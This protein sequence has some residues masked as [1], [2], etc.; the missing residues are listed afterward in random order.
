MTREFIVPRWIIHLYPPYLVG[1]IQDKGLAWCIK[2]IP[3]YIIGLI[4]DT[5]L[6]PLAIMLRVVLFAIKP[7]V[8]IRF[9]QLWCDRL[10]PFAMFPELYLC[11][12]DA[13]VKP[14]KYLDIWYHYDR[15]AYLLQ[16]PVN[17]S[18]AIC[19]QQLDAMWK[20]LI[21]VHDVARYMDRLNRILKPGSSD[22]VVD[23]ATEMADRENLLDR[24]PVHLRF[25]EEEE[26]RGLEGLQELGIGP[27]D[28]FV[29]FHGRDS[30][31]L[32]KARPRNIE[33]H[34]DWSRHD[35]RDVSIH[36]YIPAAEDMTE[37]GYFAVRMGKYVAE[38]ISSVN[39]KI[40]DYASH[41]QSDFMDV[42]L[43]ARCSFFIGQNSGMISLPQIFRKP[44]LF[45]NV[46]PI[47]DII[48]YS[49][50]SNGIA[51][52]KRYYSDVWERELTMRET[53]D[54]G[55]SDPERQ[56]SNQKSVSTPLAIRVIDNDS[57]Q[58]REA[59]NEMHRRLESTR[60]WSDEDQQLQSRF[61]SVLR[62]G[63]GTSHFERLNESPSLAL[64]TD[65]LRANKDWLE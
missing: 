29:C 4:V 40:I 2:R 42:F 38:P 34:G 10:G 59:A 20:R 50:Y 54:M 17:P 3:A 12:Q 53:F 30:V 35:V 13:G 43:A 8:H 65:Y 58:I 49:Q 37:L 52:A 14:S 44:I 31:Y 41:S 39:P 60:D 6:L 47:Q 51:I 33:T 27:D 46:Y 22:F 1:K 28:K 24:F 16:D 23:A 18:Q 19:N 5:S 62:G 9:G 15:D 56:T 11:E 55:I 32:D 7:I 61:W 48:Y 25:T 64:G 26:K 21:R 57:K 36:D 63:L 45:A